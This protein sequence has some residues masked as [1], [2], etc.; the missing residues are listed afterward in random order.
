M[1]GSA[2]KCYGTYIN[3]NGTQFNGFFIS[4]IAPHLG[5]GSASPLWIIGA[6]S[7]SVIVIGVLIGGYFIRNRQGYSTL[8]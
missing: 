3:I 1:D 8:T 4:S 5:P 2:L 6:V 7:G